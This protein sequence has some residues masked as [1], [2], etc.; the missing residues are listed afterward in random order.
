MLSLTEHVDFRYHKDLGGL[1]MV[2]AQYQQKNFGKHCHESYTISV[3]KTGVQKFYRSGGEHFAP[4]HSIILVNADDIHTGQAADGIGWSYQAIYP[5]E[6]HFKEL[7]KSIGWSG[8][9]APYFPKAV[10]YHPELARQLH[11]FFSCLQEQGN[12]MEK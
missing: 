6:S 7:A 10:V 5:L 3:I 8:N 9:Y 11:Y 2:N 12:Q 1:E 4:E